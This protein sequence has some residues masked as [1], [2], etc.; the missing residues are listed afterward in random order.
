MRDL[1]DRGAHGSR[2]GGGRPL[3]LGG[4][5]TIAWPDAAGAAQHLGQGRV[6]MIHFDA[7]AD[8][9][10]VILRLAYRPRTADARLIESG[11]L[12]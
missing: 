2:N 7:H 1:Q 12:G 11:A 10:D 4:D 9:G 5:H 3:V 6:S 8:T